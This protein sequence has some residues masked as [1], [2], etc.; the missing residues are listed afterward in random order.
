[1]GSD[2]TG[3]PS[4]SAQSRAVTVAVD[5]LPEGYHAPFW[6]ARANGAY[7][8][9]GLDVTVQDGKGS[10][11]TVQLVASGAITFGF[12]AAP[13]IIQAQAQGAPVLIVANIGKE[14]GSGVMVRSDS[15][16]KSPKD[17][18]GKTY[19]ASPYSVN[20]ILFPGYLKKAGVDATK[21]R[22]LTS[23]PAQMFSLLALKKIDA[24]GVLTYEG[25]IIFED[26]FG[27]STRTLSYADVGTR[28]LGFS[29]VV[30]KQTLQAS[31]NVVKGFVQETLKAFDWSAQQPEAAAALMAQELKERKDLPPNKVLAGVMAA[32]SKLLTDPK[33][34]GKPT[35]W[36]SEEQLRETLATMQ[37]NNQLKGAPPDV[38][39]I[40]TNEFV[41]E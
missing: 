30:T 8:R 29:L 39:S 40:Y 9:A 27:I 16:I 12:A 14:L 22:V 7:K 36:T 31:P 23:D 26:Q 19:G 24:V 15:G 20:Y 33:T 32:F 5:W 13:I 11:S 41:G 37:E 2:P 38:K 6:V 25:P 34:K 18:E 4:A 21:V 1:V 3:T 17:L 28:E 10:S 35:G